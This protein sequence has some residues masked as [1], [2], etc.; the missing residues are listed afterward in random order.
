MDIRSLQRIERLNFM[1]GGVLVAVMALVLSGPSA[2]GV[3]VGVVLSCI[4]FS[5]L[6]RMVQGWARQTPQ[7]RGSR[8]YFMVPKMALLML[9]VFLALRF[10]PITAEGL[11]IGFSVFLLSIAVETV[12]YIS[13]PPA[14]DASDSGEDES[15][16]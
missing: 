12:R 14:E 3:L 2:L 9:A 6:R 11:A 8:S 5:V 16:K 15:K 13:N 1:L 4:N 7:G 10:L